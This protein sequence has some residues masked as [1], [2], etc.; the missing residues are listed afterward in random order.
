MTL[1]RSEV[2]ES[3]TFRRLGGDDAAPLSEFLAAQ[4]RDYTKDFVPFGFGAGV[5]SAALKANS[6]RYWGIE[7]GGRLVGLTMLRFHADYSRPSFG[8]IVAEAYSKHGLGAAA[9]AFVL[10]WCRQA[11]IDEVMLKVATDNLRARRL[12]ERA[13]FSAEGTCPDTGHVIY[14]LKV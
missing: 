13:G 11:G 7:L 14:S 4:S 8:L 10:N 2:A 3:P 5:V 12:Y 1:R 6:D 9:L